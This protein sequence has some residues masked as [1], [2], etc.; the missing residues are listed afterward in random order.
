MNILCVTL[1]KKIQRFRIC[2]YFRKIFKFCDFMFAQDHY[3]GRASVL[4]FK[5]AVT[6]RFG[7]SNVVFDLFIET[8]F[9]I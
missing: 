8:P 9:C 1:K 7:H 4:N 2:N 5:D 6:P 3:P